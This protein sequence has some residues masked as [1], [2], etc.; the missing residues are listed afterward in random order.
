LTISK[1]R[2][3]ADREQATAAAFAPAHA[4]AADDA[5]RLEGALAEGV[6]GYMAFRLARPTFPRLLE[7]EELAGG[8]RLRDVPRES[9]AIED[10]F[11]VLRGVARARGLKAFRVQDAV[12]LFVSLTFSPL[13]RRSTFMAA[14]GRDLS[15][16]ATARRHAWRSSSTSSCIS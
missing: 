1:L 10:A 3:F 2:V 8:A 7:W 15:D 12:L 6:R 16:P 4:W 5:G 11:A 13:T 14:L 9:R